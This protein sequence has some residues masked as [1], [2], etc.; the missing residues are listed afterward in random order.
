MRDMEQQSTEVR[1]HHPHG[2]PPYVYHPGI[3]EIIKDADYKKGATIP[4]IAEIL[5][6]TKRTI[7]EWMQ[8]YEDVAHAVAYAR[9]LQDDDIE[10]SMFQRAKGSVV[11]W[12]DRPVGKG[13]VQRLEKLLPADVEAGFNWLYNRRPDGQDKQERDITPNGNSE[14]GIQPIK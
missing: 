11:V 2:S 5:G 10:L 7:Y 14:Q 9:S 4:E 1:Q 8:S 6:V 3:V 13:E 12:E